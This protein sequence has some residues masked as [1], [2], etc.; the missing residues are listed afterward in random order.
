[1]AAEKYLKVIKEGRNLMK[2][3]LLPGLDGTGN[4]FEPFVNALPKTIE[5]QVISYETDIKQSYKE[6]VEFVATKLPNEEFILVAESF[7]G[8]IAYEIALLKPDFLK[9]L[10]LVAT[11][12]ENPHPVLLNLLNFL[13]SSLI[14]SMPIPNSLIKVFFL[15]SSAKKETIDLF[16]RS[17]KRVSP[18]VISFRLRE[19]LQLQKSNKPCD[20]KTIYIQA[21]NDSLVPDRC[22]EAVQKVFQSINVKRVVGPHFILQANPQPCAEILMQE[23]LAK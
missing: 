13:P 2:I 23:V 14:L 9:S 12:L 15:G 17:I 5:T 22:F 3:V 21:T 1:M 4:L 7:S 20:I 16:I 19:I 11:F 10:I 8:P 18:N 6:L